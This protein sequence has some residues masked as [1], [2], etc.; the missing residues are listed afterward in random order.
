MDI[1]TSIKTITIKSYYTYNEYSYP[2]QSNIV[3][4]YS[5]LERILALRLAFR[6][7]VI[8]VNTRPIGECH[9]GRGVANQC[10][11]TASGR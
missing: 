5:A 6:V 11:V 4:R 8:P 10:I 3:E 7:V 9:V 2:S 1:L